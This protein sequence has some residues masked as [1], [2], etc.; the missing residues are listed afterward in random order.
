MPAPRA[1]RSCSAP[2]PSD[3]GACRACGAPVTEFAA[4]APLHDGIV[5]DPRRAR[6]QTSRWRGAPHRL[7]PLGRVLATALVVLFGPWGSFTFFTLLYTPVWV[8]V[9]TIILKDV[10]RKTAVAAE[11]APPGIRDRF[12]SSHPVMG[13]EIDPRILK[14]VAIAVVA[15][16][17]VIAA[18]SVHGPQLFAIAAIGSMVGLGFL[19]AWLAGI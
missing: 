15:V 3:L 4:R 17:V 8:A 1:C 9:S 10:W 2:L 16:F 19:L 18:P 5:F 7:G 14:R 6:P 11:A 13:R 12:R